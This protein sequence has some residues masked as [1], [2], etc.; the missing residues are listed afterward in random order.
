MPSDSVLGFPKYPPFRLNEPRFPQETFL[1]R[2]LHYLD[3]VDPSTLFVSD[4]RLRECVKLLDDYKLGKAFASD[5]E[6]WKAQKIKQAILHPDTGEKVLPPFR[7]SGFVPFGWITVTGM[8][9]PNPSWP[10]LLFWQWMNQS[11]NACVNY[12]NRNATQ[13]QP[14]STYLG[15]YGAAV[16]TACSISAGLTYLVKKSKS[17]APTTQLIVQRFV[18]LPAVS[19]A[20]ALNCVCMR[21]NELRTGIEVYEKGGKVIGVSKVAAKQAVTDTTLV[22]AFL[23]VPLLL[24]P[25]C[26]MPFLERYKWV[27]GSPYRHLFVN[28]IVCTLSFAFSLPVALALFPQESTIHTTAFEPEIQSKTDADQLYYNKGL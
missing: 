5:K 4:K 13:P 17:L 8:L 3:V 16:T 22:R 28:A 21:W 26:I 14:L 25:P 19:L 15:A 2:Y 12:A 24:L 1:G 23:P 20:S 6:L 7:M 10:T 11:H 9:L 27:S 18:P